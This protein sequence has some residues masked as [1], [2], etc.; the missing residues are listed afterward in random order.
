MDKQIEKYKIEGEFSC[1]RFIKNRKNYPGWHFSA[2]P[3]GISSL[4]RLIE[5]MKA[6]NWSSKKNIQLIDMH[7]INQAYPVAANK[8]NWI[9]KEYFKLNYRKNDSPETWSILKTHDTI[10]I[11]LGKNKLH[12]FEE[13]LLRL[14]KGENDFTISDEKDIDEQILWFW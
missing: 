6:S 9:R 14:N 11:I 8:K 1:W 7:V 12:E 3:N 10:E 5:I 4:L 2:D 13:A